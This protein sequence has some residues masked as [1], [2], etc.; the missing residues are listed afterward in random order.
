[1]GLFGSKNKKM[2]ERVTLLP[3]EAYDTG[4]LE[5]RDVIAPSA[6]KI[7]SKNLELGD[8]LVKTFFIISYPNYNSIL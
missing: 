3:E 7:N 5:L 6:L 8:K 4:E 2:K 1:M